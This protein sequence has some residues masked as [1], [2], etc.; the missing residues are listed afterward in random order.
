MLQAKLP[1]QSG[2]TPAATATAAPPETPK[3]TPSRPVLRF[4]GRVRDNVRARFANTPAPATTTTAPVTTATPTPATAAT[5]AE[6]PQPKS[7]GLI[8]RIRERL[9][10]KRSASTTSLHTPDQHELVETALYDQ[11]HAFGLA[12]NVQGLPNN[13]QDLSLEDKT[14]AINALPVPSKNSIFEQ[15][16][17]NLMNRRN[18]C[19]FTMPVGTVYSQM[20]TFLLLTEKLQ[21]NNEEARTALR[22]CLGA[23]DPVKD[24]LHIFTTLTAP[25]IKRYLDE[26]SPRFAAILPGKARAAAWGLG[27]R[28]DKDLDDLSTQ[29]NWRITTSAEQTAVAAHHD[30]VRP[31]PVAPKLDNKV[32]ITGTILAVLVIAGI[33]FSV[34]KFWL[35]RKKKK[36]ATSNTKKEGVLTSPKGQVK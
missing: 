9:Q 14:A 34:R 18:A 2:P 16:A 29:I 19:P 20:D 27:L 3:P 26:A 30:D 22:S 13:W 4:L 36:A 32:T 31:D 24:G 28:T 8:G 15:V 23:K 17:T 25:N 6:T 5:P 11:L 21:T 10:P 7:T 12:A 1:D 33:V 35:A